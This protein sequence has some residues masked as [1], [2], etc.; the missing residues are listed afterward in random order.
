MSLV[1]DVEPRDVRPQLSVDALRL[2]GP[3]ATSA[4][5]AISACNHRMRANSFKVPKRLV[6]AVCREDAERS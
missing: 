4:A 1:L 6:Q 5:T 2:D 3:K